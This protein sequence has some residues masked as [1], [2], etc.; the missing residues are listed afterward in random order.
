MKINDIRKDLPFVKS[1][2]KMNP[3]KIDLLV[4]HHDA[5]ESMKPYNTFKR[6]EQEANVHVHNGWGHLSY[7]YVIDNIGE[8]YYC[9]SENEVGYHAGNLPVNKNSIAIMVQGN[10]E[11][12]QVKE[13]V[14][15]SLH[16]LE[17][18]LTME[19]P[20][21]PLIVRKSVKGHKEVRLA[22]TACPGKNLFPF[23]KKF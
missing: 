13:K 1:N 2:G 14:L 16:E 11:I 7:H 19:R 10:F 15:K 20:D 6:I 17:R 23:I 18:H 4:I 9:L 21:L 3:K 5:V 8:I 22:P 12:H